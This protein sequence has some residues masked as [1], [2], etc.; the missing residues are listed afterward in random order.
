MPG[1]LECFDEQEV[2]DMQISQQPVKN[3]CRMRLGMLINRMTLCSSFT[4][5]RFIIQKP[6]DAPSSSHAAKGSCGGVVAER[7]HC[8]IPSK[9][10]GSDANH[11][12]CIC[13]QS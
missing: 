3:P 11:N 9:V 5:G 6:G 4:Y 1:G 8:G 2:K 13:E 10:P 7:Q 12:C